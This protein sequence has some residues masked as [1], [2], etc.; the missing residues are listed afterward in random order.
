MEIII[1]TAVAKNNVIGKDGKIPWHSS[2]EL[3]HFKSVTM[4]NP[5]IMGRKTFESIGKVLPGRLNIILSRSPE[6][7]NKG[8]GMVAVKNLNEALK[9]CREQKAEKVF[10]IGGESVYTE[11]MNI[12][13]KIILTRMNLNPEGDTFFPRIDFSKWLL[14]E[15]EERE[16]FTIEVYERKEK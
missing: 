4:G 1:I 9:I 13:D 14:K 16:E 6:K 7:L 11:A 3:K 2:A 5:I 8:E 12:A 15:K 10:I